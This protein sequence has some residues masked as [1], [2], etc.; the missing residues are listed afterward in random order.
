MWEPLREA[1]FLQTIFELDTPSASALAFVVLALA[2]LFFGIALIRLGG[3]FSI[4]LRPLPAYDNLKESITDAAESGH[5][6]HLSAGSDTVGGTTTIETLAGVTAVA[7][8]AGRAAASHVPTLMTTASPLVLPL[9]QA[10]SEQAYE[11]AGAPGEHIPTQVRFSGDNRSAYAVGVTD[12]IENEDI[13]DSALIGP[14]TE[15]VLLIGERSRLRNVTQTIGTVSVRALPYAVVT[16][17]QVLVGEEM[18]AAGAYLSDQ[19]S[20]VASLLAQDWLRL[21]VVATIVVGVIVKTFGG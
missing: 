15:E 19:H 17:D 8:L 4:S 21:V 16:A 18:F 5:T 3:A 9:L 6:V 10:V 12:A 13:S 2:A 1:P 14:F 7:S 11:Q 20:H